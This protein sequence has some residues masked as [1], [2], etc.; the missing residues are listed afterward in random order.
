MDQAR[1]RAAGALDLVDGEAG[2]PDAAT[3]LEIRETLLHRKAKA[4]LER[5]KRLMVP[6]MTVTER[7]PQWP[8][9]TITRVC[10][11]AQALELTSVALEQRT[12][13]IIPDVTAATLPA[14]GW[15]AETLLIEITVT[16]GV[17][18]ARLARIRDAN[19]PTLEI[20][21]SRLGGK[22]TEAEFTR[23]IL[24]EVAGKRA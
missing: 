11:D 23:L 12:S 2:L 21:L 10:R 16:N 7:S 1:A 22:V 5:E 8:R 17:D 19:L 20:D 4:I 13:R 18:F 14:P 6:Q 9:E 24:E 3:P 15:P